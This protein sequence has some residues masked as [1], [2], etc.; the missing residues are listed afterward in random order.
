M[1]GRTHEE[2]MYV[3]ERTRS[4]KKT[5]SVLHSSSISRRGDRSQADIRRDFFS[6][7]IVPQI[8]IWGRSRTGED[9]GRVALRGWRFCSEG[10]ERSTFQDGGE[11]GFMSRTESQPER[12]SPVRR[13]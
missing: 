11:G 8:V 3:R 5:K 7:L 4:R 1:R 12:L 9:G 13:K 6:Q 2:R 10:D